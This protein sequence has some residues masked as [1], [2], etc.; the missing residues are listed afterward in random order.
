MGAMTFESPRLAAFSALNFLWPLSTEWEWD[1]LV[2][3]STF[4]GASGVQASRYLWS[5]V[6]TSHDAGFVDV[7]G[8]T[9]CAPHGGAVADFHTHTPSAETAP[10]IWEITMISITQ[11]AGQNSSFT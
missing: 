9:S 7:F 10:S 4:V 5:R 2:C 1:G 11:M 3:E 8:Q 6:V